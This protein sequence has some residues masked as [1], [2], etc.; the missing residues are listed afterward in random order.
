MEK[1][2]ESGDGGVKMVSWNLKGPI[3]M[4]TFME[5]AIFP[6]DTINNHRFDSSV[7]T[8]KPRRIILI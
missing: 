4:E 8:T 2:M 3:K 6:R 5:R 7:G 1:K